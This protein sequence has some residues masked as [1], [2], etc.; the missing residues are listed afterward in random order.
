MAWPF[1]RRARLPGGPADSP[2]REIGPLGP[3][4]IS[5]LVEIFNALLAPQYAPVTWLQERVGTAARCLQLVAQQI[6]T[7]PLR[8]R[9]RVP[10]PDGQNYEPAW[11]GS[12][13]PVWYPN[14]ITDAVFAATWSMYS[15]GDAFLWATSRYETG[16]PATWTVLD[17]VTMVVEQ[18]PTGGRSYSSNG[19]DLNPDDVLQISRDPR[20]MLRG[21]GALEAYA[22]NLRSAAQGDSYAADT[23]ASGGIPNAVLKPSRRL[24]AEQAAELQA[25]WVSRVSAR[26]AAP[27]VIPPDVAFEELSFSPK[28]LMLLESREFDAKQIAA[29]FGV[30]AP[31]LNM[32]LASGLTYAN[33]AQLFDLWWR[34]E[35]MPAA[36]RVERALS[37]WLPRGSW[38]EFDPS[39]VLRPDPAGMTAT[40]INLLE[41]QV[42]TVDEVRAAVLDLPPLTQGEALDLIDE[43]PGSD[44][45]MAPV[46]PG[47]QPVPILEVVT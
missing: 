27:A 41:H 28:D 17:P 4:S 24:T 18:D 20:G 14:G 12:P 30:P 3:T 35:L 33:P 26:L 40:W 43:P 5:P 13:D 44:V 46:A 34:S 8:Y 38:V 9:R 39:I 23:L 6:A 31:L 32:G 7:M 10:A 19:F 45:S 16:Y 47:T 11:V 2:S 25:Q 15:R 29:A 42:V 1:R 22:A 36:S 37:T 21:T